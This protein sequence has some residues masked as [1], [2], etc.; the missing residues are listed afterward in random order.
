MFTMD[1]KQQH[2]NNYYPKFGIKLLPEI[3]KMLQNFSLS[4]RPKLAENPRLAPDALIKVYP[5]KYQKK[6]HQHLCLQNYKKKYFV[7]IIL[8][9]EFKDKWEQE[10]EVPE[11]WHLWSWKTFALFP[12]QNLVIRMI[13]PCLK[14]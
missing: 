1:I 7:Q 4:E 14:L 8:Y 10:G 2:N 12:K 5:C 13:G 11:G 6:R 9:G 3:Q